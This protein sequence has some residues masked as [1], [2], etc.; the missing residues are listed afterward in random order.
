MTADAID[1]Y[2]KH[3]ATVRLSG[4]AGHAQFSSIEAVENL[5]FTMI[6]QGFMYQQIS[7]LKRLR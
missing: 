5:S 2:D 1:V 7:F 4:G 3:M 6:N